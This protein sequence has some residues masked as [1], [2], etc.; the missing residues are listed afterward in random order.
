MG[1]A[2]SGTEWDTRNGTHRGG[3]ISGIMEWNPNGVGY[4]DT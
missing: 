3:Y 1:H 2:W 4:K